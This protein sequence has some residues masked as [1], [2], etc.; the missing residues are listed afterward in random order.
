MS[1]VSFV[2]VLNL[3][4]T[5]LFMTPDGCKLGL[6]FVVGRLLFNE[7]YIVETRE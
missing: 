7:Y 4:N 5:L 1:R 3:I 6:C 2:C